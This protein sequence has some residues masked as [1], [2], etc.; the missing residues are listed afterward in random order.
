LNRLLATMAKEDVS[1]AGVADLIEKDTVLAGNVLRHVNSPLYSFRGSVSSVRHAVAI[2]G[3][4]KLRNIG[5]SMSVA[6]AWAKVP[7]PAGWPAAR[8]NLHSVAVGILADLLAGQ[9]ETEYAEGAFVA[10][11]LHDL[12]KLLIAVVEPDAFA[13]L[14]KRALANGRDWTGCEQQVLGLTH[15]ALSADALERWNLPAPIRE[16]VKH[17]HAPETEGGLSRVL[18]EADAAA[19]ALGHSI[20]E[21]PETEVPERVA[22][23]IHQFTVEFDSMRTFF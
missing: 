18:A 16:A 4:N 3:L 15:A 9:V 19:N 2:L 1:F 17:H 21:R 22:P 12:G 10:G 6:R 5:L 8:F 7:V 14:R 23:L 11:L 20:L 13:E